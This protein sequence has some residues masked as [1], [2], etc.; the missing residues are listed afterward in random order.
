VVE[1]RYNRGYL[2]E[3]LGNYFVPSQIGLTCGSGAPAGFGCTNTGGNS[4]TVKDI[5]IRETYD[6]NGTYIFN[7]GGRH[8]LKGRLSENK[9]F[10]DV[11]S[12]NTALGAITFNWTR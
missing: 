4:A 1:G 2:N 7:A 12:G 5:S 6:F 11:L 3:K 8:E 10:N 9:T